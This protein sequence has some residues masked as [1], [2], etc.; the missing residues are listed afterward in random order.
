[1][2]GTSYVLLKLELHAIFFLFIMAIVV[3]RT[4]IAV[5]SMNIVRHKKEQLMYSIAKQPVKKKRYIFD[6]LC[7]HDRLY[8]TNASWHYFESGLGKGPCDCQGVA[9][10]RRSRSTGENNYTGCARPFQLGKGV[11]K[12]YHILVLFTRGI[13]L[14]WRSI[15]TRTVRP[16]LVMKAPL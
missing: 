13:W 8:G 5:L 3:A 15:N 11:R 14:C 4:V 6:I 1:M 16:I 9:A 7:R 2:S 10:K 12:E